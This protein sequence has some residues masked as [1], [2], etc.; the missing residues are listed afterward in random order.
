MNEGLNNI[1][2]SDPAYPTHNLG[3]V[4]HHVYGVL[5]P[6]VYYIHKLGLKN[7]SIPIYEAYLETLSSEFLSIM[8]VK[9]V[10]VD[11]SEIS[12]SKLDN[13]IMVVPRWDYHL[14]ALSWLKYQSEYYRGYV[15]RFQPRFPDITLFK[16]LEND[17]DSI[18]IHLREALFPIR[19]QVLSKIDLISDNPFK[20]KVLLIDRG[21]VSNDIHR[22]DF[23]KW[24]G[25]GKHSR[26]LMN[27]DALEEALLAK[28]VPVLR[29]TPGSE[30]LVNQ[31]TAF[32]SCSGVIALRG[33]ELIH[34]L[35]MPNKAKVVVIETRDILP[36]CSYSRVMSDWLE[37]DYNEIEV[38]KG[39]FVTIDPNSVLSCFS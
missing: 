8:D 37:H 31:I 11:S 5:L 27:M 25:Y 7:Q 29:F 32:A 30:S 6:A 16:E 35:W 10:I 13:E 39:R 23:F 1:I 36:G 12:N 15:E 14:L 20:D 17:P 26:S 19:N 33:A 18:E 38:R 21:P 34:T 2:L 4:Y 9:A 3:N 22:S 28:G 24:R